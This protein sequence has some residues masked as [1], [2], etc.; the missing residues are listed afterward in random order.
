MTKLIAMSTATYV[1]RTTELDNAINNFH[2]MYVNM[3]VGNTAPG[4]FVS[5]P[6]MYKVMQAAVSLL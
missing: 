6:D 3:L 2:C 5:K 1:L 4:K